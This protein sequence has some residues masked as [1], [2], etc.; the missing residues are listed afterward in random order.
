[1]TATICADFLV[2]GGGVIGLS[3]ARELRRRHPDC[4]VAVLEKEPD[5][6][7]HASGR[8]SGVLHAGF[9]YTADS[10]RARFC[11]DG[12]RAMRAFCEERGLRL[13]TCGKL[14]VAADASELPRLDELKR[15]AD[16][17][18]VPLDAITADEARAIEPRARTHERALFSPS[19]ATVDPAEVMRALRA[20]AEAAGARLCTGVEYRGRSGPDL[21]TSGGAASAGVVVNAAGL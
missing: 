9:Y 10:L 1:M 20:E 14:V 3:I 15:R 6:G 8:N 19:T 5:V 17:N 16:A 12:N 7:E 13:N 4:S 2:I 11:R 18:G 21:G